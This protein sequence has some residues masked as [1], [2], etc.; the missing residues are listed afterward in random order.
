MGSNNALAKRYM[1]SN[2]PFLPQRENGGSGTTTAA[3]AKRQSIPRKEFTE[4]WRI[5]EWRRDLLKKIVRRLYDDG[6]WRSVCN[7]PNPAVVDQIARTVAVTADRIRSI[8]RKTL[9]GKNVVLQNNSPEEGADSCVA[10][11]VAVDDVLVNEQRDRDLKGH[12]YNVEAETPV[13]VIID[14]EGTRH[15]I[16]VGTKIFY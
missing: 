15:E 10:V 7:Q 16:G 2:L 6:Y 5:A 14:K 13:L 4:H 8:A 9:K 3:A 1:K 11:R 12:I